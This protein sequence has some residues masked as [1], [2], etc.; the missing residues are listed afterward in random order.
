MKVECGVWSVMSVLVFVCGWCEAESEVEERREERRECVGVRGCR[1][2]CRSLT[3]VVC[4]YSI[5]LEHSLACT[6]SHTHPMESVI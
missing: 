3:E 6:K 4:R 2:N 5:V 1:L